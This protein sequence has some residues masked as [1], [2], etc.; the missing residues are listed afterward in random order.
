MSKD[1]SPNGGEEAMTHTGQPTVTS[2]VHDGYIVESEERVLSEPEAGEMERNMRIMERFEHPRYVTE[3]KSDDPF[4]AVWRELQRFSGDDA[5]R[6][7]MEARGIVDE[8]RLTG[9]RNE[10]RLADA[11]YISYRDAGEIIDPM[12]LY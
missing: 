10:V 11:Y 3:R 8:S 2:A 9:L 5:A 6:R 7:A 12:I 4:S 1:L